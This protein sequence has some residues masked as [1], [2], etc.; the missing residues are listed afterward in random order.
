MPP[1][2]HGGGAVSLQIDAELERLAH[3]AESLSSAVGEVV[4]AEL[5]RYFGGFVTDYLDRARNPEP[6]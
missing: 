4:L 5:R 2:R 1:G 3:S 6:D